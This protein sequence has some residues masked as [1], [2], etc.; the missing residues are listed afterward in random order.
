M[1]RTPYF[2]TPVEK[3]KRSFV[4][5]AWVDSKYSEF[6]DLLDQFNNEKVPLSGEEGYRRLI[7]PYNIDWWLDVWGAFD[8]MDVCTYEVL[9]TP[10]SLSDLHQ[11]LSIQTEHKKAHLH[12][13][14]LKAL[15][16]T[17]I[18]SDDLPTLENPVEDS[19]PLP[20]DDSK[21][22]YLPNPRRRPYV[23]ISTDSAE[24]FRTHKKWNE[25]RSDEDHMYVG[26]FDDPT[27]LRDTILGEFDVK[28]DYRGDAD[29]WTAIKREAVAQ[30]SV[31]I[32]A[33]V[34]ILDIQSDSVI[35]N[36]VRVLIFREKWDE[37]AADDDTLTKTEMSEIVVDKGIPYHPDTIDLFDYTNI[38]YQ[39]DDEDRYRLNLPNDD[40]GLVYKN[41]SE[42]LYRSLLKNNES[43]PQPEHSN[44]DQYAV[45]Q[46]VAAH[47]TVG[48]ESDSDRNVVPVDRF[49]TAFDE[50]AQLNGIKLD[51]LGFDVYRDMRKG[52][53]RNILE[54]NF[55]IERKSVRIDGEPTRVFYPV[56]LGPAM[57]ELLDIVGQIE[58]ETD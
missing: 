37:K 8:S 44:V 55:E 27:N 1:I 32:G 38:I 19:P 17:V 7:K 25:M 10:L 45:D 18:E 56:E 5:E 11:I 49:I 36:D 39:Q 6:G 51:N 21:E 46:F 16:T 31:G 15:S 24:E 47:V 9:T 35:K 12:Q 13:L 28:N 2:N 34:G 48:S 26:G 33:A 29:N 53:L 40:S 41:V 23:Y 54:D 52:E 57:I 58:Q 43:K 22:F 20:L 14:I 50:F 30:A 3:L 4:Y 42:D